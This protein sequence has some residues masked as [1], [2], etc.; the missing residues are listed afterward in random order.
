M[1]GARLGSCR[2]KEPRKVPEHMHDRMKAS[3]QK[4]HSLELLT[5]TLLHIHPTL[6][7]TARPRQP[8]RQTTLWAL[9]WGGGG[10]W[11]IAIQMLAFAKLLLH[12]VRMSARQAAGLPPALS[13]KSATFQ[14]Q[15]HGASWHSDPGLFFRHFPA[16]ALQVGYLVSLSQFPHL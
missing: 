2:R 7:F 16:A 12:L 10:L 14:G 8:R 5:D 1:T 6:E 9:T 4:H 13:W 15:A 3:T 11:L